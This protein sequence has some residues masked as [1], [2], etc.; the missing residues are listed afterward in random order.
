MSLLRV[1]KGL[2]KFLIFLVLLAAGLAIA[3]IRTQGG[4][5][6]IATQIE[7]AFAKAFEGSL[8]IGR[9]HGNP[10]GTLRAANVRLR[11]P[12]GRTVVSVDTIVAR[13][14]VLDALGR[15]V[16]IRTAQFVRPAVL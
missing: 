8:E 14:S 2:F 7:L 9:L 6:V 15:D 16:T 11:D 5:D 1:P 3:A 12:D 4:R 13:L 10:L